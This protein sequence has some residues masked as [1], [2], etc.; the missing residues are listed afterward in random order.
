MKWDLSKYFSADFWSAFFV[1]PKKL[2]YFLAKI[3]RIAF[4]SARGFQEDDCWLKASALTFYSLLSI[5]PVLAVAFGIAKGFGFQEHLETEIS[6]KFSEQKE[7]VDK[8]IDFSYRT[9]QNTQSGLIAGIGLIVLFWTVLKLFS[10][11]ESSF[12]SIWKVK[13]ARSFARSFSDYLAMMLFCPIFFFASSSLSV[14]VLTQITDISKNTGIW[15]TVSPVVLLTLHLFPLVLAWLLF[16]AL[17]SIMPNTKVPLKYAFIAGVCAGTAYQIVQFLYIQFQI[18]LSSYGAIYGSF[19]ALPLFL[20]W[21][22]TSWWIALGGA[23]I[24]YHAENDP[25]NFA[26]SSAT[27]RKKADAKVL[28]LL[29]I[30][31]CVR[32]FSS[33]APPPSIYD[34]SSH[35]GVPVVSVKQMVH[36]LIDAG[37]LVEVNWHG[38]SGEYY[39]P[40]R[41]IKSITL[42]QVCDALD[43]S[44]HDLYLMIYDDDVKHYEEALASADAVLGTSLAN[45]SMDQLV[46]PVET[47]LLL[48]SSN[49]SK[50]G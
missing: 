49:E 9:L 4:A 43:N 40:S 3:T 50:Y 22:N 6:Q 46:L 34:L 1:Q 26:L 36:Q 21:L 14:F 33:G 11:I 20:I 31:Q 24:A 27:N 41:D 44:R 18:G 5:V 47:K 15:E 7:V 42:K 28:G 10:N 38:N 2:G 16:T 13:K 48:P 32:A 30:Q 39:Q 35:S 8:L 29:I 19:A 12:N 37:L 23:E 25:I 17:Y 45:P